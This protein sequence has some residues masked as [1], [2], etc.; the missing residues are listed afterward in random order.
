MCLKQVFR[1]CEFPKPEL[2]ASLSDQHR[3]VFCW[4]DAVF[5]GLGHRSTRLFRRLQHWYQSFLID[6]MVSADPW[7]MDDPELMQ[8]TKQQPWVVRWAT[9]D[10][11]IFCS[12]EMGIHKL[13]RVSIPLC[14]ICKNY[15]LLYCKYYLTYNKSLSKKKKKKK[16]PEISWSMCTRKCEKKYMGDIK[17]IDW[18]VL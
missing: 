14:K 12:T 17:W 18:I 5:A 6:S 15:L 13:E 8:T 9:Q 11:G 4:T 10:F 16:L 7:L 1:Q 3:Q 2:I